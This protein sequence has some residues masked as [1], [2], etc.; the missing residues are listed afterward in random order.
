M[1][2]PWGV[3]LGAVLA[4]VV[5]L[6]VWGLGLVATLVV[7]GRRRKLERGDRQKNGKELLAAVIAEMEQG[8]KRC[9]HL[10]EMLQ[11]KQVSFSR[12]YTAVW[13]GLLG[14]VCEYVGSIG[15]TEALRILVRNYLLFDL[16]NFNMEQQKFGRGEAFAN[17]YLDEIRDGLAKL[18]GRKFWGE[19]F[20][21]VVE[22]GDGEDTE[23]H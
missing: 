7:E 5:A 11:D 8:L 13:D 10:A 16:V 20:V 18:K 17:E 12:V 22:A 19:R 4:L 23:R 9:E 2:D 21:E 3:V 15:D 14:E 1:S 6:I